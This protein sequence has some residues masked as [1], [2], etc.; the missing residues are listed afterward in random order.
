MCRWSL[1]TCCSYECVCVYVVF[2]CP[3]VFVAV[4]VFVF[5]FVLVCARG[6][7]CLVFVCVYIC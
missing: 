1:L 2:V 3:C 5:V 4:L 7:G 6:W